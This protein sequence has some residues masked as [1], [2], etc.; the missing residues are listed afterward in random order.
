MKIFGFEIRRVLKQKPRR[1]GYAGAKSGRLTADW[2]TSSGLVA[3]EILRWQLAVLRNRSRDLAMNN[4]YAKNFFRKLQV[5]VVG[6]KGIILQNKAR[7]RRGD[8]LD[9]PLNQ[10]IEVAW[11]QWSRKKYASVCGTL[12]LRDLLNLAVVSVA[13]D[14]EVFILKHSGYDN[15]FGYALQVLE[16]DFLDEKLNKELSDGN[17]ITLGVEKNR[18]GR[19]VAYHFFAVHPGNRQATAAQKYIRIPADKVIHLY[20]PERAGQTRGVPWLHTAIIRLRMLGAYEEASLVAAR[21]GASKMGF[22]KPP[23]TDEYI[24]DDTDSQGNTISEVE[25]GLIEVLPPGADFQE[26]DP[27]QPSG[28]FPHFQKAM[29][30]GIASGIGCSYNSLAND[31]ENVNFSSLRSGLLEE[32]DAWKTIQAWFI[33]SLL[34][35][36]YDTWLDMAALTGKVKISPEGVDRAKSPRWQARVWEWVDPLKDIKARIAALDRA[37]TSRTAICAEQGVDFEELVEQ[38]AE[39]RRVLE[40]YG[41]LDD[42]QSGTKSLT[43]G[44]RGYE[45]IFTGGNNNENGNGKK[46]Y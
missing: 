3:D 29:L 4:D 43:A 18:F 7:T 27:G 24:G 16:A 13:R 26:F 5:N 46:D 32:R 36:I 25:P 23:E 45:E 39:E 28:E 10:S 8:K 41:L 35:E 15:D 11:K 30:R 9:K 19:P 14:G 42:V 37:L 22:I 33:E 6:P 34:D 40:E 17:T 1:R 44:N 38:L 20:I 31:L 21:V 2:L 12:S